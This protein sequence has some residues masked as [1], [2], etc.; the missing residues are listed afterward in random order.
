MTLGS[1]YSVF[2]SDSGPKGPHYTKI[3]NALAGT[4]RMRD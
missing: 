1:G 3:E 4:E 2:D